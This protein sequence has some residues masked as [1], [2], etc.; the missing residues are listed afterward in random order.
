MSLVVP[1]LLVCAFA[2]ILLCWRDLNAEVEARE[3]AL[4]RQTIRDFHKSLPGVES[5]RSVTVRRL[6][7]RTYVGQIEMHLIDHA[8]PVIR[9][10]ILSRDRTG[11]IKWRAND[12]AYGDL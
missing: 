5:V 1:I 4:A 12:G 8:D 10:I 2:A 9:S 11:R 6:E 3:I 7:N